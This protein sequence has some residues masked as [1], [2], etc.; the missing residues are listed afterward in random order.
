MVSEI[1]MKDWELHK[2][3]PFITSCHEIILIVWY[4]Y[5]LLKNLVN[6]HLNL[7]Y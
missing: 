4:V 7:A 6:C 3:V 2:V 5:S 1:K